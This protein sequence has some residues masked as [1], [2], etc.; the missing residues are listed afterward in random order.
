MGKITSKE[1]ARLAGVSVSTVSIVLNNKAGVGE[2]TRKRVLDILAS[3]GIFP[4]S[5]GYMP[6][7]G[8]IRFCK[9]VKHGHII[10]DRHN[11]FISEY[12]DGVID[13][14]KSVDLSVEVATYQN[15]PISEVVQDLAKSPN[16]AGC[17]LLSTELSEEDLS[18]FASLP[19]QHVFLDAIYP[20][21]KGSFVTMDNA[22]M[23]YEAIRYL[24]ECGHKRI[25]MFTS[26]GCSN[27][28]AREEAFLDS[29]KKLALPRDDRYIIPVQSTHQGSY[30]DTKAFLIRNT[31]EILPTA[32]F[33]CNDIVAIGAIRALQECGYDVP[34][35]ISVI[36]FDDLPISCLLS[37]A[38]TTLSVPKLELGSLAVRVL[39]DDK[40][41]IGVIASRKSV[42]GGTLIHRSSVA[43]PI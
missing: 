27:F 42:L 6:S 43:L 30:E 13:E 32:F 29:L 26:S 40:T 20:Y 9:I 3:Y 11:V 28:H 10:N 22:G 38:L 4:K 16:I 8:V 14:A 2:E 25:G 7:R 34:S 36:G 41:S 19:I 23:V 35:R 18:Q 21:A 15:V 31:S 33:A 1:I 37:P 39:L 17:I 12:I 24:H 5:S